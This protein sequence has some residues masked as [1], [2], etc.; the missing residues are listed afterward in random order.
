MSPL[1]RHRHGARPGPGAPG[2]SGKR[3]ANQAVLGSFN[4]QD[5]LLV[6]TIVSYLVREPLQSALQYYLSGGPLSYLW[7]APDLLAVICM[8]S[9]LFNLMGVG[10]NLTVC[11]LIAMLSSSMFVGLY[12]SGSPAAVASAFKLGVPIFVG[13]LAREDIL[14]K[15]VIRIAAAVALVIAIGAIIYSSQHDLPWD[16]AS[17]ELGGN[18]KTFKGVA[19]LYGE[20]RFSGFSGDSHAAAFCV[21]APLMLLY[22]NRRNITFYPAVLVAAYAIFIVQSRTTLVIL[23]LFVAFC[24]CLDWRITRPVFANG[25]VLNIIV[26]AFSSV[27]VLFPLVISIWAA[28]TNL[29]DQSYELRSLW[30]RGH[31][32]WIMP[33]TF[34]DK[35]AP[36]AML[37][38][39]GLGGI[40]YPL[41]LSE[42]SEYYVPVDNFHLYNLLIFGFYYAFIYIYIVGA[43]LKDPSPG[44]K[45]IFSILSLYSI[46]L[47]GYGSPFFLI[48]Y[49][50]SFR[51]AFFPIAKPA[52]SDLATAYVRPI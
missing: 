19:Y 43:V 35:L 27:V 21:L 39:F 12:V 13:F 17:F 11:I 48:V 10:A 30:A 25:N 50:Y 15:P 51:A 40:G 31:D 34:M 23:V 14:D 2:L 24:K 4:L 36:L 20:R 44:R 46:F 33:F 7:Y 49:G 22:R 6:V 52:V 38:G 42:I 41:Y 29:S 18:E 37:H 47:S 3:R 9:F 26:F 8:A 28:S 5:A 16:K 32:S 45:V 1:D